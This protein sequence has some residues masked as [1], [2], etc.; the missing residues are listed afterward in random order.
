MEQCELKWA[1][2]AVAREYDSEAN[3]WYIYKNKLADAALEMYPEL[4]EEEVKRVVSYATGYLYQWGPETE[5]E[6]EALRCNKEHQEF[7]EDLAEEH[8]EI[9]KEAA[10]VWIKSL[11]S[12]WYDMVNMAIKGKYDDARLL[13]KSLAAFKQ[14]EPY[15]LDIVLYEFDRELR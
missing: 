10:D 4:T 8:E 2:E 1:G 3:W 14:V 15:V 5:E 6:L 7:M 13:L 9:L 11:G 12:L